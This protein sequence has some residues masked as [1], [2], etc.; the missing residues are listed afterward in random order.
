MGSL[1]VIV[2]FVL[3]TI[4]LVL[5]LS[6]WPIERLWLYL[7]GGTMSIVVGVQ[8]VIFWIIVR[9]LEELSQR[10]AMVQADMECPI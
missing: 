8:L 10:E 6:G 1:A 5:G 9:V 4:S 3:G 7:L 2:G